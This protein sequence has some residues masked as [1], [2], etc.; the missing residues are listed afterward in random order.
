MPG[1]ILDPSKEK[2][3]GTE[4]QTK[5]RDTEEIGI[6]LYLWLFSVPLYSPLLFFLRCLLAQTGTGGIGGSFYEPRPSRVAI[7]AV[8]IESVS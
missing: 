8:F 6:P 5:A 3:G 4:G 7:P 2:A 1:M